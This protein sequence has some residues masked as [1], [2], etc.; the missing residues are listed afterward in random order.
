MQVASIPS[1]SGSPKN[2]NS[3]YSIHLFWNSL[4]LR[5]S[6]ENPV[7]AQNFQCGILSDIVMLRS[8]LH[9]GYKATFCCFVVVVVVVRFP[10]SM[11]SNYFFYVLLRLAG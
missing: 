6:S 11:F 2:L 8:R 7:T 1:F 4:C 10:F 9:F 5:V 3:P